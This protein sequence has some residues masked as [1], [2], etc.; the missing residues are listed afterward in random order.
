MVEK[1]SVLVLVGGIGMQDFGAIVTKIGSVSSE[2]RE[3]ADQFSLNGE[4]HVIGPRPKMLNSI[5]IF[6]REKD[7]G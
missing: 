4:P 2:L 5:R 3:M 7:F 1:L 6:E